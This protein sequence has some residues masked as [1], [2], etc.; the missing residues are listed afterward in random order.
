V[1]HVV[2]YVGTR[3]FERTVVHHC[4]V[5]GG[6]ENIMKPRLYFRAGNHDYQGSIAAQEAYAEDPR[7]S[8]M[9]NRTVTIPLPS[10]GGGGDG[11]CL[12]LVFIDT[13]PLVQR[14]WDQTEIPGLTRSIGEA[15]TTAELAWL[16]AS[17]ATASRTCTAIAVIGHHPG[18][19]CGRHG[20]TDEILSRVFPLLV[21]HG[22][23]VYISGHDHHLSHLAYV[24]QTGESLEQIVSGG[25]SSI[26][27]AG[28]INPSTV[29]F[30]DSP[31]FTVH[32]FN[33]THAKHTFVHGDTGAEIY[34]FI[35]PHKPK[36]R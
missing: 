12:A 10:A 14:Y 36:G 5:L 34:T 1:A 31:G 4:T 32:R 23:D 18:L 20:N 33:A 29:W 24:H 35:K 16:N 17:L 11:P 7:W 3:D 19:S 13:T 6:A 9:R 21:A 27:G 28:K 26:T 2:W 25:G 22:A 15:T 30:Q 8:A